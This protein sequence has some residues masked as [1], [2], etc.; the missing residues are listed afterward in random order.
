[1]KFGQMRL[2]SIVGTLLFASGCTQIY[3]KNKI[4]GDVEAY[5]ADEFSTSKLS[6]ASKAVLPQ[7]HSPAADFK[8][9][10]VRLTSVVED[11]RGMRMNPATERIFQNLG[12]GLI[13]EI[14]NSSSNEIPIG[15]SF[16]LG[17]LGMYPFRAQSVSYGS[18]QPRGIIETR[19]VLK[20]PGDAWQ[21]Q[22]GQTYEY[23]GSIAE[24]GMIAGFIPFNISC[25]TGLSR[26]AEIFS[27][28]LSGPATE[29]SC[30]RR[31]NNVIAGKMVYMLW[32]NYGVAILMSNHSSTR[33]ETYNVLDV[34]IQ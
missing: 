11:T 23:A 27:K 6:R 5:A 9:I 19:E 17:Y 21:P 26:R 10:R 13:R 33:Q 8:T 34:Q 30:E 18:G 31:I 32:Q 7:L 22:P 24:E 28:R 4:F 1:M 14:S 25:Q 3:T 15:S 20:F 16:A 12:G 29:L 2:V